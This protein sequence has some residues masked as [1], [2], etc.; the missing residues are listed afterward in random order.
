MATAKDLALIDRARKALA[1]A[2]TLGEAAEIRDQAHAMNQAP[3]EGCSEP[4]PAT[5][6]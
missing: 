4:L 3:G 6:P 5:N 2:K 1:E